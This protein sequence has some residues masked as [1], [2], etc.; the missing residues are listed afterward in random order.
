MLDLRPIVDG[1]ARIA[2]YPWSYK[3]DF[4]DCWSVKDV[5]GWEVCEVN[6]TRETGPVN[7]EAIASMPGTIKALVAEVERLRA[8]IKTH[9]DSLDTGR[10]LS[11]ETDW[12]LW[13]VLE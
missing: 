9:R 5:D 3:K 1:L 13:E 4:D 2:P 8:A 10:G 6:M 11:D 7:G 12:K